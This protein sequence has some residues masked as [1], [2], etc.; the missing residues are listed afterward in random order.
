MTIFHI[1]DLVARKEEPT[2][3][4][5]KIERMSSVVFEIRRTDE[6]W[7]GGHNGAWLIEK[8]AIIKYGAT[9][10]ERYHNAKTHS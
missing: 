9:L 7:G 3:L 2:K 8:E 6:I 4:F 10:A 1:G 5:G